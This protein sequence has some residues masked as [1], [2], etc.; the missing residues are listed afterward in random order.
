MAKLAREHND[1]NILVLGERLIGKDEAVACLNVF[2]H[3]PF[4]GGRHERRIEKLDNFEHETEKT[5][6]NS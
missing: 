2:L 4:Q 1:A 3:T 6:E 5:M